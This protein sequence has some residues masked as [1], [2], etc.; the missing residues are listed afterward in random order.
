MAEKDTGKRK[1]AAA[2][3]IPSA[4]PNPE[5]SAPKLVTEDQAGGPGTSDFDKD[6]ADRFEGLNLC[7]EE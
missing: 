1:A 2:D 5:E 3:G 4:T 7:G 6:V